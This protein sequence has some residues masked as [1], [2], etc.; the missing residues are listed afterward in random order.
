MNYAEITE[1]VNLANCHYP[2][3][4]LSPF[5]SSTTFLLHC[6][7]LLA[8]ILRIYVVQFSRCDLPASS[9]H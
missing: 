1:V 3:K 2:T 4:Q 7:L 5:I 8:L 6:P 9:F